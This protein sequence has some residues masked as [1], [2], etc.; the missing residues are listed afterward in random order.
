MMGRSMTRCEQWV[1]FDRT[2]PEGLTLSDA[3]ISAGQL[4]HRRCD[5]LRTG[6]ILQRPRTRQVVG[7]N[8]GFEGKSQLQAE[9]IKHFQIALERADYWVDQDRFA[10]LFTCN[11]V[12]VGAGVGFQELAEKTRL[13]DRG[14]IPDY[15]S[16]DVTKTR[17]NRIFDIWHD[18]AV[19]HFLTDVKDRN[20]YMTLLAV[21]LSSHGRAIIGTFS[22]NGPDTCSGLD[23]VRYDAEKMNT[24]LSPALELEDT[25]TS[26]HVMPNGAE[27]EYM[28]FI[29]KHKNAR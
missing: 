3:K 26:I 28:Y 22:M 19:F 17:F 11:Q 27:Q 7:V 24:E 20:A 5:N 29:I 25:V 4:V 16:L 23:V 1:Q 9:L 21:S 18:R 10:S 2:N 15:L 12:G 13:D 6:Q 8:V 14:N